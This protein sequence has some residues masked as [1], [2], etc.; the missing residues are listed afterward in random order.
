MLHE[1]KQVTKLKKIEWIFIVVNE[2]TNKHILLQLHGD[3]RCSK[4]KKSSFINLYSFNRF[5]LDL[6]QS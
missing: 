1:I 2:I 5:S 6:K 3:W 4:N